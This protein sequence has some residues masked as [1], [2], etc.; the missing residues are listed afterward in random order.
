MTRL[1]LVL[2]ALLSAGGALAGALVGELTHLIER[3]RNPWVLALMAGLW[4]MPAAAG[5]VLGA[6]AAI[7]LR[8]RGR[9]RADWVTLAQTVLGALAGFAAFALA[10]LL[11][12][13]NFAP[14]LG[15]QLPFRLPTE[16]IR[17]FS[18]ALAGGLLGL[19]IG[20]E[21]PNLGLARGLVAGLVGGGLACLVFIAMGHASWGRLAG[22]TVLGMLLGALIGLMETIASGPVLDI[23]LARRRRVSVLLGAQAVTVGGG[24]DDTVV[25]PSLPHRGYIF[26]SRD[27]RV[28]VQIAGR[29]REMV[30]PGWRLTDGPITLALRT[31]GAGRRTPAR[32][33]ARRP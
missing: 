1:P 31:R 33:A 3:G 22:L 13:S 27:G 16:G 19:V 11:Y 26:R 5:L 10:Q 7:D 30:L 20:R 14:V 24:P 28:E 15:L 2:P 29:G 4:F 9:F 18:W 23:T 17:I 21:L 6:R 25:L 12:G 8:L 32:A